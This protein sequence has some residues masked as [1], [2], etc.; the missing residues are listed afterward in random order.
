MISAGGV[1]TTRSTYADTASEVTIF[2]LG[3]IGVVTSIIGL[4]TLG[5]E[6]GLAVAV[7]AGV[8]FDVSSAT[9][10]YGAYCLFSSDC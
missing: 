4:A 7:A 3:G 1:I 8:G 2:V 6:A 9:F 10:A 5:A